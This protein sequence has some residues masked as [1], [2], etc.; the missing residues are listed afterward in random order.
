MSKFFQWHLSKKLNLH[1][2][3]LVSIYGF[4]SLIRR[5]ESNLNS[6]ACE[7]SDK[8]YILG[9]GMNK[10]LA[11]AIDEIKGK[12]FSRA[13]LILESLLRQFP[14]QP[15]LFYYMGQ[16]YCREKNYEKA[17]LN[18]ETCIKK[19][20]NFIKAFSALRCVYSK[21]GI[22]QKA[23]TDGEPLHT[24]LQKKYLDRAVSFLEDINQ[25][26]PDI[27]EVLL[28][29]GK[30]LEKKKEFSK[31]ADCY[32]KVTKTCQNKEI[33]KLANDLLNRI[34]IKEIIEKVG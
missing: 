16:C 4:S 1:F 3:N 26:C 18:F 19:D 7:K 24:I 14:D 31:A 20:T 27:P 5:A 12:N 6:G 30:I 9:M 11:L 17:I 23:P 15:K 8:S 28:S 10:I 34:R 33:A 13:R 21:A 29:F 25:R 32:R 22:F 2:K